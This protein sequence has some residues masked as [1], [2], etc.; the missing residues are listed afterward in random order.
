MT[1]IDAHTVKFGQLQTQVADKL[2]ADL[3]VYA[4]KISSE[5][6]EGV[7]SAL[8]NRP[9]PKRKN[10]ALFLNTYGGDAHA[11][12]RIARAFGHHYKG[13]LTLFIGYVTVNCCAGFMPSAAD[14]NSAG[15]RA[16]LL[17][18]INLRQ[19]R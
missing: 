5:G 15:D 6:Y 13:D 16:L 3:Y 9:N 12:Y 1:E 17:R 18:S 14:R 11:A 7:S 8:E 10:A 4:G 2:E 19:P